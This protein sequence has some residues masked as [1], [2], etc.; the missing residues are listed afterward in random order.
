[1]HYI[2]LTWWL[3]GC[4]SH[5]FY[6]TSQI[7]AKKSEAGIRISTSKGVDWHYFHVMCFKFELEQSF[8][9]YIF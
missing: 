1:M 2:P 3:A 5:G 7:F 4:P 8:S 6:L 9:K